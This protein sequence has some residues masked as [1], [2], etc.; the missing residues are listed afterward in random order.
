MPFGIPKVRY[1]RRSTDRRIWMD[2]YERLFK[3]RVLF[4]CKEIRMPFVTRFIA[5][6]LLMTS[7]PEDIY[8]Y[9]NSRGGEVEASLAIY[10]SIKVM[11]P[12]VCTMAMGL[13]GSGASLILVG[14]TITKRVALPHARV[15][16]HQP[17]SDSIRQNIDELLMEGKN[18]LE[19]RNTIADIYAQNT[20]KPVDV[21][22]KDLERDSFM[23]ATEAQD[24]GI[25]DRVAKYKKENP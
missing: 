4:L 25:V 19:L 3:E 6:L 14:G 8:I 21:I 5:L 1:R 15:S 7:E 11:L 20:G 10:D 16:I 24:Y 9:M 23:S 17:S 2:L 18:M 22:Q 12:D 13:V